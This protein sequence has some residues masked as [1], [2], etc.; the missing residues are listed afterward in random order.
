MI[1]EYKLFL[2]KPRCESCKSLKKHISIAEC[3]LY[4]KYYAF[5]LF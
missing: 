4:Q 3:I 2:K 1:A 5:V